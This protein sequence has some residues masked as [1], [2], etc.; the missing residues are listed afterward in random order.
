VHI[1]AITIALLLVLCCQVLILLHLAVLPGRH[2]A[3]RLLSRKRYLRVIR[4]RQI[5]S[6]MWRLG[7]TR[8]EGAA[9]GYDDKV[10]GGLRHLPISKTLMQST[11]SVKTKIY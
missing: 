11:S 9:E 7:S 8:H 10:V 5:W 6:V 4:S 3:P 2:I 1:A